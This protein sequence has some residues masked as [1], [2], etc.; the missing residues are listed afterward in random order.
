[1]NSIWLSIKASILHN[2]LIPSP[3]LPPHIGEKGYY[4]S[5]P[6][7]ITYLPAEGKKSAAENINDD[8][9]LLEKF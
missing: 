8:L 2:T 6:V 3:I 1:M 5:S 7:K 9:N 4:S